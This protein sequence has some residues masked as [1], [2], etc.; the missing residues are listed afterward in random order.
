M[1][2]IHSKKLIKIKTTSPNNDSKTGSNNIA[3]HNIRKDT[4]NNNESY[5]S[6]NNNNDN[7]NNNS[8]NEDKMIHSISQTFKIKAQMNDNQSKSNHSKKNS[9][10]NN[11]SMSNSEDENGKI[12]K[13]VSNSKSNLI[14]KD[15]K[16]QDKYLIVSE[17]KCETYFQTYKIK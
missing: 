15:L 6:Y 3:I 7:K 4:T 2:C 9:S 14:N 8:Q 10:I 12:F 1:G 17:E 16:F 13:L 5:N 11:H